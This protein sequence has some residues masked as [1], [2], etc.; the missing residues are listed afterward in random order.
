MF[1]LS[2]AITSESWVESFCE[3]IFIKD[4]NTFT[5]G[6]VKLIRLVISSRS[7]IP[8]SLISHQDT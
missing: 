3:G 6:N 2:P 5:F 1:E 4:E 7:E 8:F